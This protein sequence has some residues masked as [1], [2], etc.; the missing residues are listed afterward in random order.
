MATPSFNHIF[1][2]SRELPQC[3]LI[4]NYQLPHSLAIQAMQDIQAIHSLAIQAIQDIQAIHI[5]AIHSL[6][7]LAILAIL[8]DPGEGPPY[9]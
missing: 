7:I 9:F 6:A 1:P 4:F 3:P 8:S 2:F 5:Q